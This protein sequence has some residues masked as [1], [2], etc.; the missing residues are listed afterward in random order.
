VFDIPC[1]VHTPFRPRPTGLFRTL[2]RW[3]FYHAHTHLVV[4]SSDHKISHPSRCDEAIS[5]NLGQRH[6]AIRY[7][8]RPNLRQFAHLLCPVGF[9]ASARAMPRGLS[10]GQAGSST[11]SRA[12]ENLAL[13]PFS[14]SVIYV[15]VS[16]S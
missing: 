10:Q 9:V 12:R 1:R 6:P 8:H 7:L 2:S 16:A 11:R 15:D 4:R 3:S 14:K 5:L 13:Q